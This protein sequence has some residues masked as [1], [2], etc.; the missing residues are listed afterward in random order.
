MANKLAILKDTYLIFTPFAAA[1]QCPPLMWGH[2]PTRRTR[3]GE[4]D[5]S[6]EREH[7]V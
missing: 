6:S 7:H 2:S 3:C 4:S 1:L 5:L